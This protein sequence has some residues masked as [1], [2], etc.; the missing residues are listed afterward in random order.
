MV[1]GIVK[2]ALCCFTCVAVS[3]A[4][5]MSSPFLLNFQGC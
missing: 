3:L 2:T 5:E 4:V 1:M